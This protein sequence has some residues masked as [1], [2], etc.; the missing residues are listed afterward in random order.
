MVKVAEYSTS[1]RALRGACSMSVMMTLSG[2]LGSSS[3]K[4]RPVS[5]S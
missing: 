5:F 4:K 1:P 2:C 3:P